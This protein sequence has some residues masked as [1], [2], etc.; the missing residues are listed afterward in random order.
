M[1]S[2]IFIFLAGI[3]NSIMDTLSFRYNTSI[4]ANTKHTQWFNPAISWKNK[5]KNGDHTQGERFPGSSTIFVALTDAW[6]FSKTIMITFICLAIITYT[7]IVNTYIDFFILYL[8]FTITFELFFS[9]IFIK[10]K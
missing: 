8:T 5:W 1:L 3:C 10:R 7:P 4:F 9:K 2:I 6:H